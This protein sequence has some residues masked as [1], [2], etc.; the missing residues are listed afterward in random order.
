MKL[1]QFVAIST[2]LLVSV[3]SS[4]QSPVRWDFSSKKLDDNRFEVRLTATIKK[5]WHVYACEQPPEAIAFPTTIRFR[6]NPLIQLKGALRTEGSLSKIKEEE[7]GIES[8]QFADRV[9]F[10]QVIELKGKVKTSVNGS[11]EFQACTDEKCLPN[12]VINFQVPVE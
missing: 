10:V 8:W 4:A 12:A 7:L 9:S 2:V 5:G 1:L 6:Q 3:S 11:V